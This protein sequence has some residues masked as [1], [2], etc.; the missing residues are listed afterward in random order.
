LSARALTIDVHAHLVGMDERSHGCLVHERMRKKVSTRGI[1]G[2]I[3]CRWGDPTET[4]DRKYLD[5]VRRSLDEAPSL[6]RVVL[7]ALDGVYGEDGKLDRERT[8]LMVPNDYAFSVAAQHEKIW[9]GCSVHPL[10]AD[11]LLEL[12]RCAKAGAVL[13]KWLPAAQAIDP[14][15]PRCQAFYAKLVALGLPLVSHVGIEFAVASQT[16]E[17]GTLERLE[18]AMKAGVR[19][20]VPHAGDL[21]ILGDRADFERLVALLARYPE[22]LIDNSALAL[23]HRGRRLSRVIARPELAPRVLHGSD[24]PLPSHSWAF[25]HKLGLGKARAIGRIPSPLEREVVLKRELGVPDQVFT[26]AVARLRI[27]TS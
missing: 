18:A 3:G 19:V 17:F 5:F 20:I 21:K 11:A 9:V 2:L 24:F 16:P 13:C 1:L 4:I 12:E 10:R 14:A 15:H 6:D 23:V 22:V 25:A 27:P 26:Q 7:Y 8:S